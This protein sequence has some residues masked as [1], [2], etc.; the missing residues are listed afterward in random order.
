MS[1][2][3]LAAIIAVILFGACILGICAAPLMSEAHLSVKTLERIKDARA[4]VVGLTGLTLGLLV[5]GANTSFEEKTKEIKTQAANVILTDR[6]LRDFGPS[7]DLAREQLRITV[8]KI[9]AQVDDAQ[10]NGAEPKK[11]FTNIHTGKIR[12]AI[13]KLTPQGDGEVWLKASALSALH[14]FSASRWRIHQEMNSSIKWP[15]V[16]VVVFWLVAIFFSLGV[17]TPR[18]AFAIT[19]MLVSAVAMA[20]AIFLMLEMD[21]PFQGYIT[22]S[23][24][25]LES[26]AQLIGGSN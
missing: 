14:E 15:L 8:K 16:Y 1:P 9:I 19:G 22:L 6:Y 20:G 5:A 23:T 24:A 18:N 11:I 4:L 3:M 10:V 12:A 13:L 21:M 17:D 2:L 7:A 25:P 26:A